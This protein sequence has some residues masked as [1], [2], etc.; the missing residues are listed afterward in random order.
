VDAYSQRLS[1]DTGV[2]SKR[3]R[4]VQVEPRELIPL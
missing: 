3:K 2:R 4:M 1:A